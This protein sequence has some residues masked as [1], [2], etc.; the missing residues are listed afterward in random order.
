MA[1]NKVHLLQR[2]PTVIPCKNP[3]CQ[4]IHWGSA[5]WGGGVKGYFNSI[6]QGQSLHLCALS[7]REQLLE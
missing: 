6:G 1:T 4:I 7:Y 3:L 5:G 2:S